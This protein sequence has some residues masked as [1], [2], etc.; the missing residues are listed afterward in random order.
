MFSFYE[1]I[2]GSVELIDKKTPIDYS[3]LL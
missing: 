3:I 1:A 2:V